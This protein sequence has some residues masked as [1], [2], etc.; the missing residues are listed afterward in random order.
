MKGS[1]EPFQLIHA[2]KSGPELL[3]IHKWTKQCPGLTAG[4][5]TRNGGVSEAPY[6]SLNLALHVN[7]QREAVVENRKRV[8][9]AIGMPFESWTCA[10]QVHGHHVHVVS[11]AERGRGRDERADAIPAADAIITQESDICLASFY[12]DCVPLLLVDPVKRVIGLAHAGWQGTVQQIAIHTI[13]KMKEA[14]GCDPQHILAAIG[15]SIS[16]C[17]YEVD[18]RVIEPIEKLFED[19]PDTARSALSYRDEAHAMVDL[20]EINRHLLLKAGIMASNIECTTW[21]TGCHTELF[22]SH[23]MEGGHTGRM[24]SWIGWKKG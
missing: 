8:A 22:Y 19:L 4:F 9:A 16:S 11:A 2:E 6:G 18:K 21:C 24:A 14:F 7:D 23:R 13:D 3:E 12:A 20:R 15:P 1:T 17:C 5:T 10:E